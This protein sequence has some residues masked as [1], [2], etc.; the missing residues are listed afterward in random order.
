MNKKFLIDELTKRMKP[1]EF[2]VMMRCNREVEYLE[3]LLNTYKE[4]E[5]VERRRTEFN[6][7]P[8][9]MGAFF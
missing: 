2:E 6:I 4:Q 3:N 8:S 7:L 1:E 5:A 9:M